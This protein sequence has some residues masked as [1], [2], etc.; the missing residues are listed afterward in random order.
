MKLRMFGI[1]NNEGGGIHF[2][3]FVDALKQ[4]VFLRDAVEEINALDN[5][6][7]AAALA[8]SSSSDVNVW[9]FPYSWLERFKGTHVVWAIFETNKPP[10]IMEF[11]R[12]SADVVWTPSA[13][14][15]DVLVA[16]GLPAETIDII[17]EGVR[18]DDRQSRCRGLQQWQTP[19]FRLGGQYKG[20]AVAVERRQLLWRPL[21][22]IQ[23]QVGEAEGGDQAGKFLRL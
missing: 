10:K 18:R 8:T 1:R 14:G 20:V 6:A 16:N 15:R 12:H 19:G 17:P 11:L 13:W 4:V 7:L 9:F 3:S 2:G 23:A 5:S 22:R 21:A